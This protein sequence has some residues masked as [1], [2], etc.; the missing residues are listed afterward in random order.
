MV[1][2]IV[3]YTLSTL[4]ILSALCVVFLQK[5]MNNVLFLILA[6]LGTSGLFIMLN[7]EFLAMM[8]II[9]YVGA[10]AIFF[11]FTVMTIEPHIIEKSTPLS[12]K[13]KFLTV[14]IV[15]I[16]MTELIMIVL[17][18][19]YLTDIKIPTNPA[20]FSLKD[21]SLKLFTENYIWLEI[22]GLILLV[23]MIGAITLLQKHLPSRE[24]LKK[25]DIQKQNLTSR[26]TA[27]KLV[28]K[29]F[30]EGVQ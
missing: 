29:N 13:K 5:P 24:R 6:F 8:L 21:L 1:E 26:R 4:V 12:K 27:V 19:F 25:Q 10:V 9:V 14:F 16:M 30:K 3:F 23:G 17:S 20:A 7:A 18:K 2:S 22:L 11:L 28:R 15:C